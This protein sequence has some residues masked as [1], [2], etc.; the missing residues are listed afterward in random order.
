MKREILSLAALT[1]MALPANAAGIGLT[2]LL[3]TPGEW[4][5]VS[6]L[7]EGREERLS[8][9]YVNAAPNFLALVPI[10]GQTLVFAS[11]VSGSGVRYVA[12][13]YEWRT[14]GAEAS[15][16]DVLDDPEAPALLTCL[17]A[18]EIP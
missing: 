9:A 2:L 14:K 18:N 12:D 11:T 16:Y 4:Q 10:E 13:R 8:V 17:E 3:D 5:H 6:Y 1:L 15:L 7:C